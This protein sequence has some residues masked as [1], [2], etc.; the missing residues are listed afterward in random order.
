MAN[1]T[2]ENN[3]LVALLK[4]PKDWQTVLNHGIYRIRGSLRYPPLMLTEKRVQYLGFYLPA[5]F[6]KLKFSVRHYA[7]VKN[8]SMAPRHECIPNEMFNAKSNDK[9]YKIDVAE[10]SALAEPIVSFR[11]RSHMV[12]IQTDEQR[13]L[14]AIEFNFLYKGSHLEEPM[15]KALIEHNI[16]PEREYPVHNRDQTAALLDFAIFCKKGNFAIEMDGRQHQATR[17]AVLSDHRRDNKLKVGKWDVVR[18]VEEDIAPNAIGKTMQQ[19]GDIVNSLGGLDTEG[20]LLPANPKMQTQAQ[21]SFFHEN[22]LD[23][24]ALRRRVRDKYESGK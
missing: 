14:N 17:E 1:K 20:G 10:P 2:N 22:H 4:N 24:L 6:G 21:L 5:C 15:F 18:Y 8:I 19:I 12:L 3:T 11:G 7:K 23:L 13:L 9:Y 16:F